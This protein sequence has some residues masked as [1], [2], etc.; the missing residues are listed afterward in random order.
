MIT[1][2]SRAS[3]L[4]ESMIVAT[5]HLKREKKYLLYIVLYVPLL[6]VYYTH[7]SVCLCADH[8]SIIIKI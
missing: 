5:V 7:L 3:K 4:K 8:S 2:S 6:I 1:L